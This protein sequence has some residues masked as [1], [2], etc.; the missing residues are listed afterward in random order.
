MASDA[1]RPEEVIGLQKETETETGF[2]TESINS[3]D[4]RLKEM[5]YRPELNRKFSLLSCLAVGFSVGL[6]HQVEDWA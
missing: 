6:S 2:G 4:L 5:G 1:K 3:D